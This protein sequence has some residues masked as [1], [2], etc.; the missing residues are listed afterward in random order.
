MWVADMDFRSAPEVIGAAE[1]A[2]SHGNYGYGKPSSDLPEIVVA[3]MEKLHGW[4]I[5][6]KWIIWLPGMVCGFNAACRASGDP[7]DEVL[8]SIPVYPPFLT[9][10]GNFGQKIVSVPLSLMN[11]RHQMD[12]EALEDA[13]TER[14]KS[15]LFCHP[16]NPVGT[17]FSCG[18]LERFAEYCLRHEFVVCSDEIHC[19]LLLD[20]D[21]KHIPLAAISPEIADRT[22]TLMAPSKTFNLPGF[23]CSF[24]IISNP[25]LRIKYKKACSGIIPDPP[26]MGFTLAETAYRYGEPWRKRLLAYLR[27]NRNLAINRLRNIPGLKPYPVSATYLLWMDARGL[28]VNDPQKF[29]E[30]KG[31][32]LSNGSDF[33][34]PGFLRLNFGCTQTLLEQA[35]DRMERAVETL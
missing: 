34:T 18:E 30:E 31:V 19:D 5:A 23:G 17:I 29:F 27:G 35:L 12:F 21:G 16:H 10:P 22:I 33:G 2:A 26:A 25:E 14:S 28:G 3:R 24:A 8:S 7:G 20:E 13:T 15:F 11:N 6:P 32:G 4:K 1:E 9:A